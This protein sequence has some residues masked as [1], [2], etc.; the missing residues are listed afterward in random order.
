MK[1]IWKDIKGF[2][3]QYQ[4]SNR[5]NVRSLERSLKV[6]DKIGREYTRVMKGKILKPS[7]NGIGY[8]YVSLTN[9]KGSRR[10]VHRLV[11]EHF[12]ERVEGLEHVNHIDNDK[13]N[14]DYTN[15]EWT[16]PKLNHQYRM[17]YGKHNRGE[18]NNLSRIS[19]EDVK[20]IRMLNN[21]GIKRRIISAMY[22]ISET[23]LSAII[24]K[25]R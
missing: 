18:S 7:D 9:Y 16:N 25:R 13:S 22:S 2:E 6:K 15:L 20:E 19:E 1:E 17:E 12:L 4:I 23:H 24:N 8:K 10:Y 5:G 21:N 14:N 11:A 3:N